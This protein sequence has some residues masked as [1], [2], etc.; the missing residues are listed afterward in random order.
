MFGGSF[1]GQQIAT[2]GDKQRLAEARLAVVG[3]RRIDLPKEDSHRAGRAKQHE[4]IS[5][6]IQEPYSYDQKRTQGN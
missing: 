5:E 1:L 4:K 2:P 3:Q 6:C